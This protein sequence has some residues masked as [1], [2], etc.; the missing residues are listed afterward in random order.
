MLSPSKVIASDPAGFSSLLVWAVV[1]VLAVLAIRYLTDRLR[2]TVATSFTQDNVALDAKPVLTEAEARFFSSLE[3]A[4]DGKYLVWPQL[5]LW[6]FIEA[7][8][9]DAGAEA[10]FKNRIDR[11]RVDFCLVDRRTRTVRMA[12]ELDDRTHERMKTQ[13]RDAFVE[14]VL[15]EAGVPL[16]RI[17]AARAYDAQ[18]IRRQLGMDQPGANSSKL[19]KA[20]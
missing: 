3:T 13:R 6:T 11:K 9:S 5:P 8:S 2:R 1:V 18:V 14:G 15:K 10:A 12:I 7:R 17:P 4:V 20:L 16:I 19:A